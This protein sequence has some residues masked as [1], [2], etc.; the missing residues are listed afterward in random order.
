MPIAARTSRARLAVAGTVTFALALG[1]ALAP[2]AALAATADRD[3][4]GLSDAFETQKSLTSPTRADTDGDGIRDDAEDLDGDGLTN[5][6]EQIAVMHPRKKDSDGDHVADP[7]EDTDADGLMTIW[8][9]R[10]GTHPRI[11]DTDGDGTRDG[12]EDPDADGLTNLEEQ[13][14]STMPRLADTD[15]DGTRDDQEDPDVDQLWNRT[16]FR[17]Q[18]RPRMADS[19]ADGIGDGLEDPD[20]D[21]LPNLAEQLLGTHPRIADT[22]GDGTRDG[23]EDADGDGLSNVAELS[24]GTDPTDPDTDGD[25]TPDGE[26]LPPT[27]GSPR[28]SDA[29][30]CPNPADHERLEHPDR[31]PPDRLELRDADLDHRDVEWPPHGLRVVR[32]LRDP[33]QRRRLRH[34][35]CQRRVHLAR[36]VGRRPVS[37]P[38]ERPARGERRGERRPAH[39]SRR[40][41]RVRPLRL[42]LARKD[43]SGH[44]KAES[45]AIFDLRSNDL[46]PAGWTSADAAG[47]PIL[48]GLI[49]YEEVAAGEIDH[50]LRFTTDETRNT[51]LYPARHQASDLSGTQYPPMGLRVR[52]KSTANLTGLSAHA[53]TIA[54]ALQHYGMILADNG[55]PWYVTGVSDA[56]STTTR[57]TSW[58]ASM[59]RTSRWSIRQGW[60]TDPDRDAARSPLG[61]NHAQWPAGGAPA[62]RSRRARRMVVPQ[63]WTGDYDGG[64]RAPRGSA[65]SRWHS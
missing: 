43:T 35:A 58:T 12:A 2:A 4:D 62:G 3:H 60:S 53:K 15:G 11:A 27:D 49:R 10:A 25:G 59:A 16:E 32:G 8:E 42:Y 39:P 22:D 30:D 34:P 40:Q 55:S 50:A 57:C 56:R 7:W 41:G 65:R 26:E 33:V 29:A 63:G 64:S 51:Y 28:L 45:G 20:A 38:G 24:I 37:D 21:G 23:A 46:R 9:F 47:L 52:L 1:L 14:A 54:V 17:A 48:P 31:R 44:W 5:R 6:Q 18:T 61:E 19:D 13:T 36:R